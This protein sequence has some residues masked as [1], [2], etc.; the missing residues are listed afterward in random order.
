[1]KT[2]ATLI[3]G[4]TLAAM[5][6]IAHAREITFSGK[7]WT[8]RNSGTSTSGPG[9]NYWSDFTDNVWLDANGYLHLKITHVGDKWYCPEV[10]TKDKFGL[11]EYQFWLIGRIDDFD[12][13]IAFG[14]F[15]FPTPDLGVSGSHEIDFEFSKWGG[16]SSVPNALY[17][18]YPN[19][20]PQG[21]I[22]VA[23]QD[24]WRFDLDNSNPN[25]WTTHRYT[26]TE[27]SI[28]FQS[29]YGHYNDATNLF[30]SWTYNAAT[31]T[32]TPTPGDVNHSLAAM[33]VHLN[34]WCFN[35]PPSNGQEVE[36]VVR[37][38]KFTP[39]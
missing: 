2:I 15:Q 31:D 29:Q 17:T 36:I 12:P 6:Q 26:R 24:K 39:L 25:P 3:I 1:M 32:Y 27:N 19:V 9:P 11:G 28:L 38:F 34:L 4:I 10:T 8:V 5:G 18:V 7:Q 23:G 22:R 16:S 14:L 35:G 20:N 13:H 37:A 33:P 30:H 21:P